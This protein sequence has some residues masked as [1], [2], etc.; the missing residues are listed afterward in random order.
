MN[1]Q[2]FKPTG[3]AGTSGSSRKQG[4]VPRL[5]AAVAEALEPRRL[6]ANIVVMTAGEDAGN[7]TPTF[8]GSE[9]N[10]QTLRDAIVFANSQ[11]AAEM[12]TFAAGLFP[13]AEQ[14]RISEQ[15]GTLSITDTSQLTIQGPGM[16]LL[17]ISGNHINTVIDVSAGA[18]A[19]IENV[20]IT[21]GASSNGQGGGINSNG[22]LALVD[23]LISGNTSAGFVPMRVSGG[24]GIYSSGSL[25]LQHDYIENNESKNGGGELGGGIYSRGSLTTAGNSPSV[26]SG[27]IAQS[28]GGGILIAGQGTANLSDID[29][30]SN[31]GGDGVGIWDR[32]TLVLSDST[33]A[34]NDALGYNGG[35]IRVDPGASL[36]LTDSTITGNTA[37]G[38]TDGVDD[39]GGIYFNSTVALSM[40]SGCTISDNTA[41]FQGGG[42]YA[43]VDEGAPPTLTVSDTTI[44]QNSAPMGGG[45][46][47]HATNLNVFDCTISGNSSSG[48]GSGAGIFDETPANYGEPYLGNT[49][50]WGN[51]ESGG[52]GGSKPDDL[53]AVPASG[54]SPGLPNGSPAGEF[55]GAY[56]LIGV[57]NSGSFSNHDA[58]HNLVGE[59]PLLG[60]LANNG[61]PTETMALLSGSPV[62]G[63]GAIEYVPLGAGIYSPITTDQRGY[64]RSAGGGPDIGAYQVQPSV[65]YVD[66]SSQASNP[67][68]MTWAQAFNNIPSALV[69]A[70]VGTTIEVAQGRYYVSGASSTIQLADNVKLMGGYAGIV[71]PTAPRNLGLYPTS[72]IGGDGHANSEPYHVVTA[73]GTNSTAVLDGFT[74]SYGDA[75]GTGDAYSGYGGG[76]ID[77]GGS[78]S[79]NNC[80]FTSNTALEYGGAIYNGSSASPTLTDCLFAHNSVTAGG[81]YGIGGAVCEGNASTPSFT[82]CTFTGNSASTAGGALG[83]TSESVATVTNCILRDDAAGGDEEIFNDE[84]AGALANVRYSDIQG[85]YAGSGNINAD[86]LFVSGSV[87]QLSAGSPCINRGSNAAIAGTSTDL[88]GNPRIAPTNGVVDMGAYEYQGPFI[89]YVSQ[90]ATGAN[91]G[92][93]WHDAFTSLAQALGAAS[94]GYTILVAEGDYS[95]VGQ[96][97]ALQNGVI[98]KGGYSSSGAGPNPSAYPTFLDGS[99]VN[100]PVVSGG[101]TD[102]SAVLAD[103]TIENGNVSGSGGGI[104]NN[105]GSP[106]IIDCTFANNRAGQSGGGMYNT[107]LSSPTLLSCVFAGNTTSGSGGAI[108]NND[109][110]PAIDSCTFAGNSADAAGGAVQNSNSS[111]PTVTSC[112][113][114]GNNAPTGPEIANT[115][116]S[117]SISGSNIEG[118]SIGGGN[119]NADP[120]FVSGA[121]LQL[122][123]GSPCIGTGGTTQALYNSVLAGYTTDAAGYPR[124]PTTRNID[125]GAY[126]YEGFSGLAF[127]QQPTGA[128]INTSISPPIKVDVEQGGVLNTASSA[129]ITLSIASSPSGAGLGGTLS[130]NAVN[131]QAT[132]S[133]VSVN[134]SGNYTL[135]AQSTVGSA[136]SASFYV[137][138]SGAL[139]HLVYNVPPPAVITNGQVIQPNIVVDIEDPNGNIIN[140]NSRVSLYI[141]G[142]T[143]LASTFAVRGV[144][145]FPNLAV[146][147]S[148]A[149]PGMYTIEAEDGNYGTATVNVT[150]E[151]PTPVDQLVFAAPPTNA[152]V[153]VPVSPSITVTE[154]N[155]SG[156]TLTN[157]SSGTVSLS[158]STV[159]G[160]ASGSLSAPVV[161]GVA[162]FS[163]TPATADSYQFT[164]LETGFLGANLSFSTSASV[165]HL[166]FATE[167]GTTMDGQAVA[168][169]SSPVVVDV[170]DQFGNLITNDNVQLSLFPRSGYVAGQTTVAAMNGVA[171]FGTSYQ[172]SVYI[173]G[174]TNTYYL[175][176]TDTTDPSATPATSQPFVVTPAAPYSLQVS[177][178][179]AAAGSSF[180]VTVQELDIY[181]NRIATSGDTISLSIGSGP[182][183]AAPLG[184]TPTASLED[185]IATFN[186]LTLETA[187]A[188]K[189]LATDAQVSNLSGDGGCTISAAAPTQLTFVQQPGN[190]AAGTSFQPPVSVAVEDQFGNIVTSEQSAVTLEL[191]SPAGG[192]LNG[193]VTVPVQNGIATFPGISIG[194]PGTGYM[195]D[196]TDGGYASALTNSFN[197]VAPVTY[198][199]DQNAAGADD[200]LDWPDAFTNLQSALA[201]AVPGDSI[202]VAQGDYSPGS[203][204]TDTF[205]LIDGVSIRG[206]YPTGGFGAPNP[207]LYPTVLDGRGSNY[208]VV[209]AGGTNSSAEL[210]GFTIT[211]GNASGSGDANSRFGGGLFL[212]GGSTTI[213][214]CTFTANTAMSGGA[215]YDADQSSPAL[216]DCQ[217]KDNTA[218]TE[219]GAMANL[220]SSPTV[221]DCAFI[222]NS[223]P[224]DGAV[225]NEN[226]N[227]AFTN[228]LFAG[229]AATAQSAGAMYNFGSSPTLTN[230]TFSTNSAA[231][232]GG[233]LENDSSPAATSNPTIINCILW[234]DTAAIASG[235]ISNEAVEGGEF[236]QS[237][238]S[239]SYSDVAGGDTSNG[240]INADPMF[241][242]PAAGQFQLQ[243][244]SPCIDAG[245]NLAPGLVGISKDLAGN[246]RINGAAVDLGAYEAE[247]VVPTLVSSQVGDGSAQRSS[248]SSL[249]VTFSEPVNFTAASFTL[250]QSQDGTNWTDV[251]SGVSASNPSGD[252]ETWVISCIPGGILDRTAATPA[253]VGLLV[254]GTYRLTVHGA[255]ITSGGGPSSQGVPLNGGSDLVVSFSSSSGPS[256]YVV[257]SGPAIVTGISPATGPT[258][259][260]TSVVITG[261]NFT[262]ASAVTFGGIPAMSFTVNSPTQITAI[263]P[264][265]TTA[266]MVNVQVTAPGGTSATST[267][268]QFTYVSAP[269]PTVLSVTTNDGE[270]DGNT[271]Q[272][273]EVRQLVVTFSQAVNLTQPGAFSLGVYNL[274]GTGG[275]V[276]GNGANDGSI[277]NISS[278]LN[279]ATTTNGGLIWTITFAPGTSNTD[280]SASLIDGIYSFSINNSDVTS[281][282]VALTGSNTYTFHRLYGDVTGAGA[283]NNTDA[284]AFSEA[285]GAAAGSANYNAAFDFGGAGANINNTDAR[286][287]SLRYGQTFSSV[288]PPGGIN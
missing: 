212:L 183:G 280:A 82:N 166:Q 164:A 193:I 155:G 61:G 184:G 245:D 274:N 161:D 251:S 127:A 159:G 173:G 40:I 276:S 27:N 223:A 107:N 284:R 287:F 65:L 14:Q 119:I 106:E 58:N 11:N 150:T 151:A 234:N 100:F 116:S 206:G 153:G 24:G 42:I 29:V 201:I 218:A 70:G 215:M 258:A 273:S 101:G 198:L 102:G 281:N 13:P 56:N 15:F 23:S 80:I 186:D 134:E 174:F 35:G 104:Y 220:E 232:F 160:T 5:L 69:E 108:Y 200:G 7:A 210:D 190:T 3:L 88:A 241:V 33:V 211:G 90:A 259:G 270:G 189:L 185:G 146:D 229:N 199:V 10:A 83:Q 39:G 55:A 9:Y 19:S 254:N 52:G 208:H 187:G 62:I 224:S 205:E 50:V 261:T 135:M 156:Q 79:I 76:M 149:P 53:D 227:A 81:L 125:M 60:P 283:V 43:D 197:I 34:N 113:L 66:A 286:D 168:G 222:G 123:T 171:T 170:V 154:T 145:T 209:T 265:T 87:G 269:A 282:G 239:I 143:P 167:P 225:Y 176:A 266:G 77:I 99:H 68:G 98:I 182:A 221:I 162:T 188:Y 4:K 74:I 277:T 84:T 275:A 49:I 172:D 247:L 114:W 96:S 226:N 249:T 136:V 118:D 94:P 262:G 267:S 21:D 1:R 59:N 231:A 48:A 109:S 240:D 133:N 178:G 278:V 72:L 248:V 236:G 64:P 246:P 117:T 89:I 26:I 22:T 285:Y 141:D 73:S 67:T 204:P 260:G 158:Y 272:A 138:V 103:F 142:I 243:P 132:F 54:P 38:G 271:V 130:E 41:S 213:S 180:Q 255:S 256:D 92:A 253:P 237:T 288:L 91:T 233:A 252:G 268:D 25:S 28:G 131:G 129:S 105:S 18:N 115:A 137:S 157:D 120:M 37:S 175:I 194:Q 8:D 17:D 148:V 207:L 264:S 20:S 257:I 235:E 238:P 124:L 128:L 85:G 95:P 36:V 228:C 47:A 181:G 16:N 250:E 57:D 46:F 51:D 112:I 214:D 97:F 192:T 152:V 230:C 216:D 140:D 121:N 78:P 263:D 169:T 179:S 177:T 144:A 6:L 12:I 75:S 217:F 93:D 71:N 30:L 122:N 203:A 165:K 242:N 279:T 139:T 191:A 2:P 219:A 31:T 126:T 244:T 44:V 86:P 202:D 110:S 45:I 63:A 32:G 163:F 196:A 195:L 111:G 147:A